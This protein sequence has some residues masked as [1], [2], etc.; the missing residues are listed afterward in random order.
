MLMVVVIIMV[1]LLEDIKNLVMAEKAEIWG[2]KITLKLKH[3][4]LPKK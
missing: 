1:H 3:F 2:L 4:T